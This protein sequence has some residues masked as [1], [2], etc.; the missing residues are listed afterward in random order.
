MDTISSDIYSVY[1][2]TI[3]GTCSEIKLYWK[4]RG[5]ENAHVQAHS[6]FH[7]ATGNIYNGS[8]NTTFSY[9]RSYSPILMLRMNQSFSTSRIKI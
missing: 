2:Y 4:G 1:N 5:N 3:K 7:M 6:L 8:E 9:H